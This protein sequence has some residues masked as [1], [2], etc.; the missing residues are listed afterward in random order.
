MEFSRVV[1]E[2]S[3]ETGAEVDSAAIRAAFE[4]AFI[5]ADEPLAFVRHRSEEEP[6]DE[7][8][9]RLVATVRFRGTEREIEGHGNGP[10]DAFV[11]AVVRAF[12]VDFRVV[13]YHQHATGSG[14]DAQSACY[15]EVQAG[16]AETRY[17]AALDANI[18]VASLKAVC[19]AFNRAVED[20]LITPAA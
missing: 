8:R 20:E 10:V 6:D 13:D 17:G 1:Q 14:A 2:I 19:S 18:V 5:R 3:E 7:S 15:F 4:R 9:R 16:R 12:D 11:D